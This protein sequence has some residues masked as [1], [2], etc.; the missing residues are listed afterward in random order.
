M[1]YKTFY[2]YVSED[3]NGETRENYLG[4]FYEYRDDEKSEWKPEPSYYT[5]WY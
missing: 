4:G 5:E 3:E 1:K 2:D